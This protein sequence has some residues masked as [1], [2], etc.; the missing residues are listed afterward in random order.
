MEL[1]N[2]TLQ[3]AKKQYESGNTL[4][5]L[6]LIT[7]CIEWMGAMLDDKPLKSP[8]QSKR[9]FNKAIELLL[10][11]KYAMFNRDSFFYEY[12]R[13]PLI[14]SGKLSKRFVLIEAPINNHLCLNDNK[15]WMFVPT[16]FIH[17]MQASFRK[18]EKIK[19]AEK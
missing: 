10:R 17:D 3:E 1:I 18:L 4:L 15:Q 13:N 12:W 8:K 5:A 6:I 16:V 7:L 2:Q 14:H 19:K 11:G 9:R